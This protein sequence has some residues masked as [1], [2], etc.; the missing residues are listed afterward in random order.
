MSIIEISQCK[1]AKE[2][3]RILEITHEGTNQVKDFKV[4]ILE[5]DY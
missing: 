1:T 3:W 5:N 4:R 2:I